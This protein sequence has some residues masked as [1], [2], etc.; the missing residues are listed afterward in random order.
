MRHSNTGSRGE[1]ST[2]KQTVSQVRLNRL[3]K[4]NF[5]QSE[6]PPSETA[7][8]IL[9]EKNLIRVQVRNG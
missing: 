2:A 8:A 3:G 1:V 9:T 5:L 6:E 4:V 7:A